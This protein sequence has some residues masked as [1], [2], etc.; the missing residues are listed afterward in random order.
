[1]IQKYP[2][3]IQ[4]FSEIR[5][6]GG[7]IYVDKTPF[8]EALINQGKFYFL[9]RPRRFGKSPF[10]STLQYLFQGRKELFEGLHIEDKWDWSV[11]NPVINIPFS[12]IGHKEKG[13]KNAINDSLDS[14]AKNYGIIYTF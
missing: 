14:T 11:T 9:S 6:T 4:D 1:M 7:Y 5:T 10:V 3:G 2:V 12:N 13:L 8:I